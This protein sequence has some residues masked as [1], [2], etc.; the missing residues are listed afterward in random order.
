MTGGV[1]IIGE[2]FGGRALTRALLDGGS[3]DWLE[4][5]PNGMAAWAARVRS[6]G[7]GADRGLAA[8]LWPAFGDPRDAAGDRLRRALAAGVVVTTGQQP[9]LFGGPLYGWHKAL[10]ALALADALADAVPGVPVAPVFW[11]ATDDAD[12]REAAAT[13]IAVPGGARELRLAGPPTDGIPMADVPLDRAEMLGLAEAL[14]A[15]AGS[16]THGEALAL[17]GRCYDGGTTVGGAYVALM[18]GVL[19]PMGIAVLDASHPAAREAMDAGCRAALAAAGD[20]DRAL[21]ARDAEIR[22]RGLE[23]QVSGVAGLSLVFRKRDAGKRRIPLAEAA[24]AA[25]AAG[26]GELGP[27]VLLR[28]VLERAILPTVAYAAGPGEYAYFAQSTAVAEA[29][30]AARPLALPRWSG[31]IIEPHVR[32]VLDRHRLAP[33]DL[34]DPHAAERRIA[35]A[36]VPPEARARL[37]AARATLDAAVASLG[38]ALRPLG[39]PAAVPEGLRRTIGHRIDRLER[40]ILAAVKRREAEAMRDVATARGALFPNGARQER[41]LNL[42]PLLARH[43]PGLLRDLLAAASGHARTLLGGAARGAPSAPGS[44]AAA[45]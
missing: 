16:A 43:G 30:G 9:G 21:T 38:T 1:E 22:G 8:R 24:T 34:R 37:D 40:R 23:P 29:L 27:N 41:A 7:A 36:G 12:W 35:A 33:G 10:T 5:A 19:E 28:P 2:G 45:R 32:R 25:R 15:G 31:T 14:R 6:V 18:R 26:A 20:I 11:A 42:I 17:A 3:A 4:P 39:V 13:W 44:A